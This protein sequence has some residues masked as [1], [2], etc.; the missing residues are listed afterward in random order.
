[1][2]ILFLGTGAADYS[3]ADRFSPGYRR[4]SSLLIDE[5]ILIDPGPCV[6]EA[7]AH[8]Q[9]DPAKIKYILCT[10]L[11]E[12]HFDRNTLI[13]LQQQG[14]QYVLL[15][16]GKPQQIGMYIVTA[17]AGN[18]SIPVQHFIIDDQKSKLFYGLDSAWLM[19][20]EIQAIRSQKIDFAVL[21]GTVGFIDGDYRVFE[22][23]SMD[24]VLTMAPSLF[25]YIKRICISHMAKT[26]HTDHTQLAERLQPYHIEVAY[27]G[28]STAF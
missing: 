12:D 26:L 15:E 11:H 18:H 1:M 14:A 27:D 16:N 3:E 24:M 22:H 5:T 25:P 20:D 28:W 13:F 19:Y 4:N 9:V 7:I 8:F 21:D 6:P 10:H 17:I 2:H 23:N